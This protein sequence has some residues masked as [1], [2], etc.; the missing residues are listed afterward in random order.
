MYVSRFLENEGQLLI[1]TRGSMIVVIFSCIDL[2]YKK[3]GG[4]YKK[5]LNLKGRIYDFFSYYIIVIP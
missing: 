2:F 3:K 5:Y 1:T 4:Q